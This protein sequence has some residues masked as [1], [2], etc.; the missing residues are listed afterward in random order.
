MGRGFCTSIV[1]LLTPKLNLRLPTMECGRPRKSST[2]LS[3]NLLSR[4]LTVVHG[5]KSP[6][7]SQGAHR[8]RLI[9]NQLHTWLERRTLTTD[10]KSS[11]IKLGNNRTCGSHFRRRIWIKKLR[12]STFGYAAYPMRTSLNAKRLGVH[13]S[14]QAL[15][16]K[17]VSLPHAS[18]HTS[19]IL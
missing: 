6:S 2:S 5:R 10:G 7:S 19:C 11:S 9:G 16:T 12:R 8:R 14:T 15:C 4:G 18:R 17:S 13:D 1:R 3:A